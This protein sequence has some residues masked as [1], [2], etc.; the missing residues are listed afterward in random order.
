[1]IQ[2]FRKLIV[3]SLRDFSDPVPEKRFRLPGAAAGRQNRIN[4]TRECIGIPGG[5]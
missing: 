1:L 3:C 5:A 4:H 2:K